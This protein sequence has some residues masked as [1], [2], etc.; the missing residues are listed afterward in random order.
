MPW[1][2]MSTMSLRREFVMLASREGANHTLLCRRFGISRKTGYKWLER[3]AREGPSG[4]AEVSRRPHSTPSKVSPAV[5]QTV[6][7]LR[8]AH[9]DWGARTL[10]RRLQARSTRTSNAVSSAPKSCTG[11]I[12]LTPVR[13]R[14]RRSAASSARKGRRTSCRMAMC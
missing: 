3:F 2:E 1:Q 10:R 8:D 13:W 4:L 5:E 7:N 6:L 9:P 12:S 14:K 11:T